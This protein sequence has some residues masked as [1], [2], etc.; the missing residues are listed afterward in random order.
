VGTPRAVEQ[1]VAS[2]ERR[3]DHRIL[4]PD[5]EIWREAGILAGLVARL[6][7]YGKSERRRVLN[8]ALIYLSAARNGCAVL[9]RNVDDF[10]FLMQLAPFGRVVF[11]EQSRIGD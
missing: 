10:D 4:N 3:P 9:T 11:Y 6:Q 1:I 7:H 2:I 5:A 8:D